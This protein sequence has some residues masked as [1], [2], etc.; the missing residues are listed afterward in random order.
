[1]EETRTN[2]SKKIFFRRLSK[3]SILLILF[4][5]VLFIF[6]W[7]RQ[8]KDLE[9][10]VKNNEYFDV[11]V[12]KEEMVQMFYNTI[13]DLT[14]MVRLGRELL[15][16]GK[17]QY[18]LE[19]RDFIRLKPF[20]KSFVII[21]R[22]NRKHIIDH[23]GMRIV[24][25]TP[26]FDKPL[27]QKN[28]IVISPVKKLSDEF[29]FVYFYTRI[30]LDPSKKLLGWSVMK[31]GFEEIYKLINKINISNLGQI[32]L[33]DPQTER[34]FTSA[35]IEINENIFLSSNIVIDKV[36]P[37]LKEDIFKNESNQWDVSHGLITYDSFHFFPLD[38]LESTDKAKMIL[39][40]EDVSISFV[41]LKIL[42]FV[43]VRVLN[44]FLNKDVKNI[45]LM[46]LLSLLLAIISS[47]I[48]LKIK[49]KQE[50]TDAVLAEEREKAIH[51]SKMAT[52]GEMAS[53]IAHEINNPLAVIVGYCEEIQFL[54]KDSKIKLEDLKKG[55]EILFGKNDYS[56][57]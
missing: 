46:Y 17:E 26:E 24:K 7:Q 1:M 40:S 42:S 49:V 34:L 44:E 39:G 36:F 29:P 31:F 12:K 11:I 4:F 38:Y 48:Y 57:H 6:I 45:I 2:S 21:D 10:K 28:S 8:Q 54:S 50:I 52:I 35:R 23:S 22:K 47:Y 55:F 14:Y 20:Y 41:P 37:H 25:K 3:M 43:S 32:V 15:E 16:K 51:R 53:G 30:P 27:L 19:L 5:T 33:L 56:E 9:D 18:Y 13:L